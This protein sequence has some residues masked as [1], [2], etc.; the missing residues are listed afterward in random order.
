MSFVGIKNEKW[1]KADVMVNSKAISDF[2]NQYLTLSSNGRS[3]TFSH[4]EY[5]VPNLID[6]LEKADPNTAFIKVSYEWNRYEKPIVMGVSVD[7]IMK[8]DESGLTLDYGDKGDSFTTVNTIDT[9]AAL[10]RKISEAES[11]RENRL[12]P[13]KSV[14]SKREIPRQFEDI[15]EIAR[16]SSFGPEVG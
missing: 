3:E 11:R 15:T 8:V 7:H 14:Q 5:D 12:N 6:K 1:N 10:L 9:Q 2:T 4:G 13:E 16:S